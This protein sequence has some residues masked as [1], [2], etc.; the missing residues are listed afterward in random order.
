MRVQFE[1][2]VSSVA[3]SPNSRWLAVAS[4]DGSTRVIETATGAEVSKASFGWGVTSVDFSPDGRWLA[5][6]SFDNTARVFEAASGNEV[7]R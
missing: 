1:D 3:F 4:F 5:A 7:S 6:A 2:R